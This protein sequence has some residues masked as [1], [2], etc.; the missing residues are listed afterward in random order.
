M[1]ITIVLVYHHTG[2][3]DEAVVMAGEEEAPQNQEAAITAELA[4]NFSRSLCCGHYY[5]YA[6]VAVARVDDNS[7]FGGQWSAIYSLVMSVPSA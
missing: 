1:M 4:L 3:R 6:V 2:F 5:Y 7:S